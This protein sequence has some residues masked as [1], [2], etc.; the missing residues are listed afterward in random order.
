[1]DIIQRIKNDIKSDKKTKFDVF[2]DVLKLI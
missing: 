2:K 1:M